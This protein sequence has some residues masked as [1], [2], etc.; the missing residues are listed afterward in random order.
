MAKDRLQQV[1]QGK[2]DNYLLPFFWLH[3]E[4]QEVVEEYIEKMYACGC[5]AFCVESRPHPD[6]LGEGWW[7]DMDIILDKAESL[8]MKVWILDDAHFPTGY[9]NGR[10]ATAPDEVKQWYVHH[11]EIDIAGPVKNGRVAVTTAPGRNGMVPEGEEVISVV[12]VKRVNEQDF[13][14]DGEF[15]DLTDQ[16]KDGWL[17]LNLPEGYY[18]LY[19]T[20]KFRRENRPFG[21]YIDLANPESVKLLIEETYE[22]H[23]AHYKERFGKT[24]AGFFSDE[25]G[26]YNSEHPNGYVF[27]SQ[28][29][30]DMLI[31]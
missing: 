23:Y 24:I 5:R 17:R 2:E 1:L 18:R 12:L 21:N 16:V 13:D 29:G 3:G 19:V 9:A 11:K 10:I 4:K 26:F 14:T 25:P 7:S 30:A 31:P 27:D 20:V 28:I 6:F 15:V 22:K 8:G